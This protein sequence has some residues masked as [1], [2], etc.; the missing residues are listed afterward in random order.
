MTA[1]GD[2]IAPAGAAPVTSGGLGYGGSVAATAVTLRVVDPEAFM[3]VRLSSG[4]GLDHPHDADGVMARVR[5][6]REPPL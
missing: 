1:P 3:T 2:G 5:H 4:S 6:D